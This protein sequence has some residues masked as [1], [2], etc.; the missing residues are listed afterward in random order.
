VTWYTGAEGRRGLHHAIS[1]D[2]G[3]SFGPPHALQGDRPLPVSVAALAP[4]G[5]RVWRAWE[6]RSAA[7][8][9][10]LVAPVGGRPTTLGPG[11]A[12]AIVGG[13]AGATVAWLRPGAVLLASV[14]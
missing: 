3:R 8:Q 13:P 10:I 6:D 7:D 5:D 1:E 9:V 2:G 14:R 4:A 11:V 12:P